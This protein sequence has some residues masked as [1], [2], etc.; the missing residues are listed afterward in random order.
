MLETFSHPSWAIHLAPDSES[1]VELAAVLQLPVGAVPARPSASKY[2]T[3]PGSLFGAA[4]PRNP[5]SAE[6]LKAEEYWIKQFR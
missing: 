4:N 2:T 5:L 1:I 3:L 6:G